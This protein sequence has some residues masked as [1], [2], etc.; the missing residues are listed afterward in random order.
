[1]NILSRYEVETV[2]SDKKVFFMANLTNHIE[3]ILRNP[4]AAMDVR[5]NS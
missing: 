1:M 4:N 5:Y 2:F 3:S